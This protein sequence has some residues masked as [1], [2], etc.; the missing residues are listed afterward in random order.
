MKFW[1]F[2]AAMMGPRFFG[3]LLFCLRSGWRCSS[4]ASY[5]RKHIE[6]STEWRTQKSCPLKEAGYLI[7]GGEIRTSVVR[8]WTADPAPAW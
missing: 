6:Y 7:S 5:T 3:R 1:F 4:I 2:L 8:I